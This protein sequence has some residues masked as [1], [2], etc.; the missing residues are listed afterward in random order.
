[1]KILLVSTIKRKVV[2]ESTASRSQII[3]K[4]ASGMV[5]KGH[6]VSILGT[7]DTY[8][9]GVKTIP[10]IEKGWV[11]LPPAEN[12]F[13]LQV[14]TLI[15]LTDKLIRIQNSFDII[16][17]HLYPEFFTPVIENRL[18]TPMVTTV[19][20]Q[21][22]DFID[23]TLSL[24][25]KAYFV[26]ISR[27]H[28]LQFKKAHIYKIIYNGI[29]TSLFSF[30][31]SKGDYLLWIGR[32][33]KAKDK[34]GRFMDPKGVRWAIKL[35]RET[36]QK[37]VLTGNVEDIEFYNRDV[38]PYLSDK[39]T[40]FGPVSKEQR[41]SHKEVA[42]LMQNAKAFLMTINWYEPFGLVMAEAMSC[43]TPVIAFNRGS[44]PELVADGKT[45]FVIPPEEGVKGLKKALKKINMISPKDCRQHV[46]NNFSQEKMVENYEKL[47]K[48]V[49]IKHKI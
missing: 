17:N 12:P 4:I 43:G 22:T 25:K 27:A 29:D 2:K 24:F 32:L 31:K 1:M 15:Q 33:S 18:N 8:I 13:F 20:S 23:K 45:G 47:Y 48:E 3:Y 11:D 39:I 10:V 41:L 7:G 9:K 30:Q 42:H 34:Q 44:V 49:L 36:G 46:V 19:H 35:A 37:L 26:S 6:Q 38:K 5:K 40:W 14:A 21:A 28:R 16:H